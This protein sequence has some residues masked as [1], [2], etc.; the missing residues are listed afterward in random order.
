M[1]PGARVPTPG[2]RLLEPD[3]R[4]GRPE[5]PRAGAST[6]TAGTAR[7]SPRRPGRSSTARPPRATSPTGPSCSAAPAEPADS[8]DVSLLIFRLGDE[9]LALRARGR[10]RGD[11][12]PP[13]PPDPAPLQRVFVGPGRTSGASCSSAS[14]CTACSASTR[15]TRRGRRPPAS[16]RLVVIRQDGRDL[17]LRGRRGRWAST[18]SPRDRLRQRPLDPGQPGRQLQPGGLRLARAGASASSTSSGSSR[19]CRSLGQ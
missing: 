16:P 10:R 18:G 11:R 15:P 3:R 1:T 9:W 13:G 12:A 8:D 6:S 4:R 19:R 7:S 14:R 5:L 17:G 2:R